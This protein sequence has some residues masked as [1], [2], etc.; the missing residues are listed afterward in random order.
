VAIEQSVL[1][2]DDTPEMAGLLEAHLSSFGYDTQVASTGAQALDILQRGFRGPV[3]L[4]LRLP[5]YQNLDLFH[6][7]QRLDP[8]IPVIIITAHGTVDLAVKATNQGAFDFLNKNDTLLERAHL[9]TKNALDQLQLRRQLQELTGGQGGASPFPNIVTVAPNMLGLFRV[10][11]QAADS[12]VTVLISGESGTGKELVAQALHTASSR[13]SG[14]FV[15]VNCAGIPETLLESELFGH[16]KGAFTGAVSRKI[17]KFEQAVG[18]TLFLDEVGELPLTLQPKLLRALQEREIERV[19]GARPI[20]VDVRIVCATNRDLDTEVEE[21]RF[22]E[23]LYYRLAVLPLEVPPLR[24]RPGDVLAL[25]Q[26]FLWF[27]SREEQK[28]FDGYEPEVL[29]LL[30]EHNF[31]GNVREIQN[32]VRHAVVLSTSKRIQVED[33]P[34]SMR[35][36]AQAFSADTSPGDWDVWVS[37]MLSNPEHIPSLEHLED[38]VIKRALD[39]CGGNLV[40]TARRLGISRA[41]MYRRIDKMGWKRSK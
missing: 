10:M 25:A 24:D 40:R 18:G 15:A 34:L 12:Q 8:T 22:R 6:E 7:I 32:V 31:P 38:M 37:S 35:K 17:G 23:D 29:Q 4:D 36:G 14:P 9:A 20:P 5:D 16:E 3:L 39:I 41:T 30:S 21:R 2:V 28:K 11:K 27:Y 1:I 26:H 19:G 33:L 13:G